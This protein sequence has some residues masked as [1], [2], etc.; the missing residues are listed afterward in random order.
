MAITP[1]VWPAKFE[2]K[3]ALL[4]VN[5][6]TSGFSSLPPFDRFIRVTLKSAA[7]NAAVVAKRKR[8][9]RSQNLCGV[10]DS[11]KNGLTAIAGWTAAGVKAMRFPSEI[12]F[13][14]DAGELKSR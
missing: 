12:D 9:S 3:V 5:G 10:G 2:A 13:W 4:A 14:A 8:F 7:H 1:A 11:G 6:R